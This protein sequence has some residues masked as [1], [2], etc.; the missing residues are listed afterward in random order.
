[1]SRRSPKS[2]QDRLPPLRLSIWGV[3]VQVGLGFLLLAA[4]T[5]PNADREAEVL[6]LWLLMP[7]AALA[8]GLGRAGTTRRTRLEQL[9]VSGFLVF[10]AIDAFGV[11]IMNEVLAGWLAAALVILAHE[12]GRAFTIQALGLRPSIKLYWADE[13]VITPIGLA[14]L[15]R[16]RQLLVVLTGPIVGMMVGALAW[17]IGA[18]QGGVAHAVARTALWAAGVW[19]VVNL[20]PILPLNGGRVL[21]ELLSGDRLHRLRRARITSGV[22]A[23]FAVLVAVLLGRVDLDLW[24]IPAWFVIRSINETDLYSVPAHP[25]GSPKAL[26]DALSHLSVASAPEAEQLAR[27]ALALKGVLPSHESR[28]TNLL[29][30]SYLIRGQHAEARA[31]ISDHPDAMYPESQPSVPFRELAVLGDLA[32][33]ALESRVSASAEVQDVRTLAV[34]RSLVGEWDRLLELVQS[35]LGA[36][37]DP[38]TLVLCRTRAFFAGAFRVSALIGEE[39]E[40]REGI[41]RALA[42]YNTACGWARA[43]ELEAGLAALERAAAA[44]FSD[45]ELLD[46]DEDLALLRELKGYA[47]IRRH[48]RSGRPRHARKARG[49]AVGLVGCGVAVAAL[50]LLLP[51]H[52]RTS[53]SRGGKI[54]MASE[55]V[56]VDVGS[57]RVRWRADVGGFYPYVRA[58]GDRVIFHTIDTGRGGTL[59]ILDP[60][61]GDRLVTI[62]NSSSQ[63]IG[64]NGSIVVVEEFGGGADDAGRLVGYDLET[65]KEQWARDVIGGLATLVGDV[66]VVSTTDGIGLKAVDI[67]TGKMLWK[68]DDL[69]G[70]DND[71]TESHDVVLAKSEDADR[72][73]ALDPRTGKERWSTAIDGPVA[74]MDRHVWSRETP[75]TQVL[76]DIASGSRRT[77]TVENVP[78]D[79]IIELGEIAIVQT[80][81]GIS[82]IDLM[83]GETRWH[84]TAHPSLRARAVDDVIVVEWSGGIVAYDLASGER[85]WRSSRHVLAT[86]ASATGGIV[87]VSEGQDVK[88]LDAHDGHVRWSVDTGLSAPGAALVDSTLVVARR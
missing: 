43:G 41:V 11:S 22:I 69:V 78:S 42:A 60:L 23:G 48:V 21:S 87:V 59:S 58:E 28:A 73:I 17:W 54:P 82:A 80:D 70:I 25:S 8:N 38:T 52:D 1:M 49:A 13:H 65:G 30:A 57:G 16:C 76:T 83:S 71:N 35:P 64:V 26:D 66:A 86:A 7:I 36:Y 46:G 68:H 40:G 6:T 39:M 19:G 67:E 47:D 37:L 2:T 5:M 12:F 81:G 62:S 33:G 45:L 75:T 55:L 20:L 63:P 61:D 79:P 32:G 4:I 27:E 15:G 24:T 85:R 18:H 31:V 44:G 10:V 9:A 3:P 34:H 72:L 74:V 14:E 77:I 53:I 84:Q 50:V 51:D 29:L 88:G 56:G